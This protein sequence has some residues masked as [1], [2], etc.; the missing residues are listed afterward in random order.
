[1]KKICSVA[2]A[3]AMTIAMAV[4][5]LAANGS[6]V[7]DSKVVGG[8]AYDKDGNA[9]TGDINDYV[10]VGKGSQT[11]EKLDGQ[12]VL[13]TVDV[14]LA[15]DVASATV[16]LQ[17]LGV[18]AG[19][20]VTFR[21][22]SDGKWI[23]V[24]GKAVADN[25]VEVTLPGSGTLAVYVAESTTGGE[26]T[27]NPSTGGTGSKGSGSASTGSGSGAGSATSPKTGETS[28]VAVA[29]LMAVVLA[30]AA[31]VAGKKANA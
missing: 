24:E 31:V 14:T 28:A 26:S 8:T 6:P 20:T 22:F 17:V 21:F 15:D 10:S 23:T 1:M 16:T 12:K 30:G 25:Q 19:E 4:T 27:Q 9:L 7:E 11:A 5:A 18:K 29:V 3:F 13:D 2:L